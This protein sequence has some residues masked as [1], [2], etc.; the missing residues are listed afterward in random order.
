M[1]A[2]DG[3]KTAHIFREKAPSQI[4][5]FIS[6]GREYVFDA[7]DVEAFWYLLKPVDDKKLK[8]VLQKAVIKTE[9]RSQE[10]SNIL[11]LC[12]RKNK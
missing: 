2:L 5:I 7:Y 12:C 6:S 8:N 9:N 3:M 10:L 4:L 1:H 11:H